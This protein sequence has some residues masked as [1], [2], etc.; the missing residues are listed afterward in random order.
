MSQNSSE[1]RISLGEEIHKEQISNVTKHSYIRKNYKKKSTIIE[2]PEYMEEHP[3]NR[4]HIHEDM[5]SE[6]S[7]E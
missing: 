4:G 7:N 5:L 1:R 3:E 2:A 6:D